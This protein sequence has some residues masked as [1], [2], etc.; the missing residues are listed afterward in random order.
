L[1]Y[2][3]NKKSEKI[4]FFLKTLVLQTLTGLKLGVRKFF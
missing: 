1:N 4:K 3:K 2:P